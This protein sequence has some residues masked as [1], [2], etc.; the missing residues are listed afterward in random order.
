MAEI[1]YTGLATFG[2]Q[3]Q[4]EFLRELR[5]KEGQK[6]FR[7]MSLNSPDVGAIMLTIEE[8]VRGVGWFFQSDD[9]ADD[10]RL[11]LLEAARDNL[12]VSWNDHI[13][14]V[15]TMLVYGWSL[16]EIVYERVEG[17]VLWHKFAPRGQDTL[18]RWG[19]DSNGGLVYFSQV[20]A[21]TY[22]EVKIP[23]EK[24]L[25][26]RT[27]V[28]KGNP[29]GRSLFRSCWIPYFFVKNLQ[30][31]EAIS[32]ERGGAGFPVINIP[33]TASDQ[34]ISVAEQA[35]RNI[36]IDE[37]MGF[38]EPQGWALRFEGMNGSSLDFNTPITR[39]RQQILMAVLSQF[40][41][42]GQQGVGSLALSEDQTDLFDQA[43]NAI[44]DQIAS[45]ITKFAIP[46]L[47][48]LNGVDPKG[49]RM[50]HGQAGEADIKGMADFLS[51][52]AAAGLITWT[53]DDEV[54]LRDYGGLPEIEEQTIIDEQ[55][56]KAS[57]AAQIAQSQ[58]SQG[59]DENDEPSQD[60]NG[61]MTI[62][63]RVM[64]DIFRAYGFHRLR[65]KRPK[66]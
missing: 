57:V 13:S 3:V 11:E 19:I 62:D 41:M 61:E 63:A 22:K 27:R 31:V 21:P 65:V 1:G 56:R 30:T 42:L 50:D 43:I 46:R 14:E 35:V 9:G 34:D 12:T 18:F 28:E 45:V 24:C 2:G 20:A 38:V 59:S 44:C 39:Y 66:K 64:G 51:K 40:L 47:C 49:L 6:R 32:L 4:E 54:W 23:I 25:L 7:E 29:E 37:Q 33:A 53:V 36:R 55:E 58:A 48:K 5:G 8:T 16:F 60:K 17:R 26:Y 52:I 10:P 15:L